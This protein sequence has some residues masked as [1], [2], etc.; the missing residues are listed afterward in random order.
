MP[1]YNILRNINSTAHKKY[2]VPD[3][4]GYLATKNSQGK[5]ISSARQPIVFIDNSEE[6]VLQIDE[7]LDG[8]DFKEFANSLRDY[9]YILDGSYI[10]CLLDEK[11]ILIS[12]NFLQPI[13]L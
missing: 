13:L 7:A 1:I 2:N 5:W 11:V 3:P 12:K 6:T 4:F 10:P 9:H 8:N